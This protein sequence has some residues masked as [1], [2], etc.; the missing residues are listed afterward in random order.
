MQE[1]QL[2]VLLLLAYLAKIA[3]CNLEKQSML[4]FIQ[5]KVT[6][7]VNWKNGQVG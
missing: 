3:V 7:K 2:L 4:I 1:Q 5:E 6:E